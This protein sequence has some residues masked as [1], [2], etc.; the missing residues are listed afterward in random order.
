MIGYNRKGVIIM[1]QRMQDEDVPNGKDAL[2]LYNQGYIT[3]ERLEEI[4]KI[5][6][7]KSKRKYARK[8]YKEN[9]ER[10]LEEKKV[11]QKEIYYPRKK[12]R[13]MQEKN[14]SIATNG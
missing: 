10:I 13:M 3:Y 8:Y 11:Y 12:E 4:R 2:E 14:G 9:R 7:R 5:N 6:N 1:I